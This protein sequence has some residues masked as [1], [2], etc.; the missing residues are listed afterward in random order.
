LPEGKHHLPIVT[1]GATPAPDE[2]E[3]REWHWAGIS[4]LLVTAISILLFPMVL[5][6]ALGSGAIGPEIPERLRSLS[7]ERARTALVRIAIGCALASG[8]AAFASGVVAGRLKRARTR[9]EPIVG[10]AFAALVWSLLA[11]RAWAVLVFAPPMALAVWAGQAAG[12]HWRARV[13]SPKPQ[14]TPD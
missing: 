12:R 5:S 6:F 1:G 8:L 13:D 3:A 10:M 4:A 11:G 14:R 9:L 2:G 7:P